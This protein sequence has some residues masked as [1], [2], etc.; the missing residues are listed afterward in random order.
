MIYHVINRG[1]CRQEVFHKDADFLAFVGLLGEAKEKHPVKLMGYC[2]M[3]NHFHLLLSPEK[4]DDLSKFMQWFM[5]SHVR[6]YHRHYRTSGHVWQGRYKSFIVEKDRHLL[7]VARYIEANPIRVNLVQS[8]H[9]WRWSSHGERLDIC[10][11]QLVD[12]LPIELP[13]KWTE[14]VNTPLTESE[15]ERMQQSVNRGAPF[16]SIPWQMTICEN[17]GLESTVRAKGRPRKWGQEK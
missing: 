13:V 5:T 10:A 3:P 11:R 17:L 9:E 15:M 16:G 2:L 7:T 12:E 14:Y 4:A 6:R 8:A 1:N